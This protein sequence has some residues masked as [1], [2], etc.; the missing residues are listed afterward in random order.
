MQGRVSKLNH[1]R[2]EDYYPYVVSSEVRYEQ[3]ATLGTKRGCRLP[4]NL[5]WCLE[6]LFSY[7][8]R[9]LCNKAPRAIADCTMT[10][11]R[12]DELT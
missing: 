4:H 10:I 5:T 7:R 2:T 9:G 3:D 1:P 12:C 6:M 11:Q 8:L